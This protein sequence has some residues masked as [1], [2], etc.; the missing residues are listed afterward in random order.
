LLQPIVADG[1]RRPDRLFHIALFEEM[2]LLLGIRRPDA[3]EAI[4][5]KLDANGNAVRLTLTC[6][7]ALRLLCLRQ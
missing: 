6:G 5:H 4:R 3:G 1:L 7:I 2:P